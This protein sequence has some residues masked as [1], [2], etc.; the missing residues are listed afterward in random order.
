VTADVFH[1]L[2]AA[3]GPAHGQLGVIDMPDLIGVK[4]RPLA[5][6]ARPHDRLRICAR[7]YLDFLSSAMERTQ[8]RRA[9]AGLD[10]HMLR[11][12]G[13]TRNEAMQECAM[14]FWR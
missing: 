3:H 7:K 10:D 9:L 5:C 2:I 13:I 1:V 11:D 14:P 8:Q 12:I 6:L 4:T